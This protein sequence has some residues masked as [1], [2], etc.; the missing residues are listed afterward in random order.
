MKGKRFKSKSKNT[1]SIMYLIIMLVFVSMFIFSL[2]KIIEW[3]K[4][5][6]A[7][8]K[9]IEE[10]QDTCFI[11]EG[12]EDIEKYS[13]DFKKLKEKN[14]DT[15]AWIKINGTDIKYPV[16]KTNN[17]EYYLNH[18]FDKSENGAGW[19]FM[20]YRNIGDTTDDNMIIYGHNRR[21]GGMFGT[22]K[23]ILT[24]EWQN[25]KENLTIPFV[26]EKIKKEYKV[27]SVYK[28]EKED[29]YITTKFNTSEEFGSF[30]ENIKSRSI[31][32]FGVDV[33]KDD[34]ILTISTCANNNNYRVVLHAKKIE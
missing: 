19:V 11:D 22:L 21:D 1:P 20:D 7:R 5:N 30:I 27:F 34:K 14:A 3:L 16:V 33:T 10:I 24:E 18:G 9:V 15:V 32:D 6:K 25:N 28:I 17:N 31:K 4:D 23:N 26:S 2:I 29:Y 13:I 8:D 12:K